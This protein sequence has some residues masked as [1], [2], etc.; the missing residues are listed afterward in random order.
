MIVKYREEGQWYLSSVS[1]LEGWPEAV[2]L[3]LDDPLVTVDAL[4]QAWESDLE[5]ANYHSM[6]DVPRNL[7]NVLGFVGCTEAQVKEAL[8]EILTTQGGWIR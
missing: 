8:W 6:M 2:E 3:K 4:V 1:K 5:G 7:A